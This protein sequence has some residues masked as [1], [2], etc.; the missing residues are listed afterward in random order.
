MTTSPGANCSLPGKRHRLRAATHFDRQRRSLHRRAVLRAQLRAELL[1]LDRE[2]RRPT[3]DSRRVSRRPR[4]AD[5][6]SA[7]FATTTPPASCCVSTPSRGTRSWR[8]RSPASGRMLSQGNG[9]RP[10]MYL[11]V[12]RRRTIC[13]PPRALTA[14]HQ[15]VAGESARR[16]CSPSDRARASRR[17]ATAVLSL[18]S[19]IMMSS[20]QAGERALRIVDVFRAVDRMHPRVERRVLER[21]RRGV[22]HLV[23]L[24]RRQRV[25]ALLVDDAAAHLGEI[26]VVVGDPLATP[27]ATASAADESIDMATSPAGRSRFTFHE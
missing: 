5:A 11:R 13:R 14:L 1:V 16:A 23:D 22:H 24:L 9:S 2:C 3:R 21:H 6:P 10:S 26:G 25:E 15:S 17:R 19:R 20:M 7:T 4:A 27:R 18:A 8:A 12:E